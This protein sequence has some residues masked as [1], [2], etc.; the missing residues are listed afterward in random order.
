MIGRR[1]DDDK[2]DAGAKA[3]VDEMR[4]PM[5]RAA[6]M[7]LSLAILTKLKCGSVPG[8]SQLLFWDELKHTEIK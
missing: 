7:P 4:A 5:A 8:H 2:D 3:L 1:Q 6:T